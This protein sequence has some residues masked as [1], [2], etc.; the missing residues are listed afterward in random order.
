MADS[1]AFTTFVLYMLGMAALAI[2][3]FFVNRSTNKSFGTA[4]K[5]DSTHF[6][7]EQNVGSFIVRMNMVA[8]FVSGYV[9]VGLPDVGAGLGPASL[10]FLMLCT[11]CGST[12]NIMWPKIGRLVKHRNYLGPN[13][14][15]I[16]LYNSQCVRIIT[17]F[18]GIFRGSAD[19]R[20]SR[21]FLTPLCIFLPPSIR[22]SWRHLA[23]TNRLCY[24]F[25]PPADPRYFQCLHGTGD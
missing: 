23:V 20:G 7:G 10:S 21:G 12:M 11:C 18:G 19:S 24:R 9:V 14:F 4:A 3:G 16:D 8:T 5:V 6:L 15:A 1:I 13:D 17:S 2:R 22:F 25:D